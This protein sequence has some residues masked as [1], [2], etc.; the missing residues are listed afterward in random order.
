MLSLIRTTSIEI[1]MRYG[2]PTRD[3]AELIDRTERWIYGGLNRYR[4]FLG[5]VTSRQFGACKFICR[6]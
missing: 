2:I 5:S 3:V 1:S 6:L 4:S